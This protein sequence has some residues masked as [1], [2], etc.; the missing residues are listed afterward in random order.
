MD[1]LLVEQVQRGD[2]E[3]Y[4]AVAFALSDRL[5]AMAPDPARLRRRRD[6]LQV[7]LVRSGATS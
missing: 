5:F 2:R 7:A 1:R 6:A 4:Q 3:A